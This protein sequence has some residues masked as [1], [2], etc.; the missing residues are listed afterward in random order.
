MMRFDSDMFDVVID[1]GMFQ[2]GVA[3]AC[4]QS[5]SKLH[6]LEA[7]AAVEHIVLTGGNSL[8]P[9]FAERF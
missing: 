3:E 6:P 2:A 9:N 7:Q 4:W 8:L 1:I 5:L